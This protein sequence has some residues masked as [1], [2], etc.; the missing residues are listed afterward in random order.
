MMSACCDYKTM[1]A[2][3][4]QKRFKT[5]IALFYIYTLLIYVTNMLSCYLP[6]K[7]S[8]GLAGCPYNNVKT[9]LLHY[10]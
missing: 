7:W 3:Y 6:L 8:A 5:Q 4:R 10:D 1:Q 2:Q 9:T